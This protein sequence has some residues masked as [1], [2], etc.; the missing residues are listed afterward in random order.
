MKEFRGPDDLMDEELSAVCFVRDY[1]EF[2]FDGPILRALS[3]VRI[4]D[5]SGSVT[6]STGMDGWRDALCK[7]IGLEVAEVV[8]DELHAITV[9]FSTGSALVVPIDNNSKVAGEAAHFLARV[10]APLVVW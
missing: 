3:T 1:V 4:V 5:S 10:N 6:S 8:V 7:L 9:R 2:H